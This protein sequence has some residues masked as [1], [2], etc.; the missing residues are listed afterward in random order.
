[1]TVSGRDGRTRVRIWMGGRERYGRA[2]VDSNTQMP[3][4]V[5]ADSSLERQSSKCVGAA[6]H[7]YYRQ[8]YITGLW[9]TSLVP[10]RDPSKNSLDQIK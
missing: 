5:T 10:T 6:V 1:M 8:Q 3:K 9:I 2:A 4:N 7:R